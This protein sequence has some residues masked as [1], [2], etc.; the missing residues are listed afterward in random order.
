MSASS[1]LHVPFGHSRWNKYVVL[2]SGGRPFQLREIYSAHRQRKGSVPV[3]F[4]A[5]SAR[6]YHITDVRNDPMIECGPP[7]RALRPTHTERTSAVITHSRRS[8]F[9]STGA[10]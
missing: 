1:P 10:S 8:C 4:S 2:H 7:S 6:A 3:T 5:C 9:Q